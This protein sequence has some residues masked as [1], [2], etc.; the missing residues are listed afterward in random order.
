MR[1]LL[2]LPFL[3]LF[4]IASAQD[5]LSSYRTDIGVNIAPFYARLLGGELDDE[6]LEIALRQ[7]INT[8]YSFK[9]KL[10]FY[11]Y[12]F[13]NIYS[14]FHK[15]FKSTIIEQTTDST[16]TNV[17]KF[18]ENINEWNLYLSIERNFKFKK[19][20]FILG[21]GLIPGIV[22]NRTLTYNT[23]Y[24]YGRMMEAGFQGENYYSTFKIGASPY[25]AFSIPLNKR[26]YILIQTN[27]EWDYYFN[28]L[29]PFDGTADT[30]NNYSYFSTLPIIGEMSIMYRFNKK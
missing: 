29:K 26:L 21:L 15:P 7:K 20:H 27:F 14:M 12:P 4:Q 18:Q 24:K 10:S 11:K 2:L 23:D 16:S 25:L 5:T 6:K 17:D 8:K 13:M 3:T 9:T 19:I 28:K 30:K 1:K 22:K